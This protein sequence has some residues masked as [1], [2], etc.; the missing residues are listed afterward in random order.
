[1]GGVAYDVLTAL[2]ALLVAA[3]ALIQDRINNVNERYAAILE[4][5]RDNETEAVILDITVSPYAS[6]AFIAGIGFGTRLGLPQG[7]RIRWPATATVLAHDAT[8]KKVGD[9][10]LRDLTPIQLPTLIQ[11]RENTLPPNPGEPNI[12]REQ[13]W[14]KGQLQLAA[15]GQQALYCLHEARRWLAWRKASIV[16]LALASIGAIGAAF[17]PT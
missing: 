14:Q 7:V 11:A 10:I 8:I 5:V 13:R 4:R 16:A 17:L 6:P 12:L 1:M 9:G 3:Y 2:A 15:D